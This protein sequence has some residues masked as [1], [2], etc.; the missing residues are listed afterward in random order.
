MRKSDNNSTDEFRREA[1]IA[2]Q[3]S[4]EA[5]LKVEHDS[6]VGKTSQRF[7]VGPVSSADGRSG[8]IHRVILSVD[9]R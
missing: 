3:C 5:K 8:E 7:Q 4:T 6:I 2:V 1:G 9:S